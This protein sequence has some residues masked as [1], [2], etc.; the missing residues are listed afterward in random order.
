M[1]SYIVRIYR[2]EQHTRKKMLG[3]VA[4]VNGGGDQSFTSAEELWHILEDN[5]NSV[6]GN[7][8]HR[9]VHHGKRE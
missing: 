6:D 2:H 4:G 7:N 3:V 1:D 5:R 8:S 9:G